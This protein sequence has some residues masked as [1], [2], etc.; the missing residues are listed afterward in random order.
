MNPNDIL[1][2]ADYQVLHAYMILPD[3]LPE[4]VEHIDYENDGQTSAPL[5]GWE[6][7]RNGYRTIAEKIT[8]ILSR[9]Q[10][11][12]WGLACPPML[13]RQITA[14]LPDGFRSTLALIAETEVETV[15]ISNV[16]KIFDSN[17]KDYSAHK[18][19]C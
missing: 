5:V 3:G 18:E 10:P 12:A 7:G 9:Y 11:A 16:C 19:H 1:V 6:D 17:A 14:W 8:E 4:I 13:S 2:V 15:D